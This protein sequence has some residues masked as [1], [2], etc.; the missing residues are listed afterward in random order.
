KRLLAQKASRDSES[1]SGPCSHNEFVVQHQLTGGA[2]LTPT[3]YN[4]PRD[5]LKG[6]FGAWVCSYTFTKPPSVSNSTCPVG[7]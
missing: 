4:Q 7:G 3:P 5:P 6:L 1:F 2:S